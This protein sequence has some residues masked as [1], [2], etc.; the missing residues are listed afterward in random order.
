MISRIERGEGKPGEIEIIDSL[1][2]NI[3]GR[4]VCPLGDAAVMPIMSSLKLFRDEW[5]Y[6]IQNKKCL[7]KTEFEF[8]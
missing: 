8:K 7:V 1:C 3:M 2:E 6:H 5:E 4:T